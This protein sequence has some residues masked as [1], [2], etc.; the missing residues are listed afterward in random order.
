MWHLLQVKPLTGDVQDPP[1][2][3]AASH[4]TYCLSQVSNIIGLSTY[5]LFHSFVIPIACLFSWNG[6]I[7]FLNLV[8]SGSVASGI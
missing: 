6:V 5:L 4:Y 8:R 2:V 7:G 1:F 3:T